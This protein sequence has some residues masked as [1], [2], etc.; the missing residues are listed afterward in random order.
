MPELATGGYA[1]RLKALRDQLAKDGFDGFIVP[2]TDEHQGEYVPP[3][4]QRLAWLSG[5]TGSAGLGAVLAERAA[6]FVDGRYTI[7][8]R[9]EVEE[10]LFTYQ[11]LT[12][13]P[14]HK[15]L[16]T[17]VT[18][19]MRIAYDPWLQSENQ[20]KALRKGVE[21]AGGELVPV[22][23]NPLDKVWSDQPARPSGKS[24]PYDLKHAGRSSRDKRIEIGKTLIESGADCAV[25]SLPDSVAWLLNVR[26]E[27]VDH[28]P[29]VLSFAIVHTDGTVQW[30][31][32]SNKVTSETLSALDNQVEIAEPAALENRLTSFAREGKTVLVDPASCP[33][34]ITSALEKNG[35]KLV[36]AMDPI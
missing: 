18:Q 21:K 30:F 1:A 14:A 24:M 16:E 7:Q 33:E 20:V 22:E 2:R 27:D 35:A 13:E 15:W 5:F 11:H 12:E 3:Q 6:I 29:L 28:T 4:A 19:G 25:L 31:V 10:S 8:V 17:N 9:Q 32:D 34:R 36:R 23:S 26:G